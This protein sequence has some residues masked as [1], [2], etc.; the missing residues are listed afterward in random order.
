[1]YDVN[2]EQ[3]LNFAPRKGEADPDSNEDD[4][5]PGCLPSQVF[6][7][8]RSLAE[9][10]SVAVTEKQ[11]LIKQENSQNSDTSETLSTEGFESD[12]NK[13][14]SSDSNISFAI[15]SIHHF[16]QSV[17]V[18]STPT[19]I[20]QIEGINSTDPLTP[21]ANLKMLMSVVSPAIRDLE[22]KRKDLFY[23]DGESVAEEVVIEKPIVY[24][25]KDKS[26]GLLCQ[27]FL[28]KFPEN[29][30]NNPIEISL[31]EVSKDLKVERRR[32]Y[33]IVNVLESVEVLSRVAKNRYLW[34]GKTRIAQTLGRLKVLSK[35]QELTPPRRNGKENAN[36]TPNTS[37][38]KM[39]RHFSAGDL[40]KWKNCGT[41]MDNRGLKDRDLTKEE[42]RM[43]IKAA[44]DSTDHC[45]KDKSLGVLS[46]KFLIMFLLSKGGVV[47]L[48]DAA[49]VLLDEKD[50]GN[51]KYKT[52]VRR[53]YDIANIL[54]SLELIEKVHIRGPSGK[55]P[56]FKWIGVDIDSLPENAMPTGPVLTFKTKHSLLPDSNGFIQ[57]KRPAT[58]TRQSLLLPL[59]HIANGN[60]ADPNVRWSKSASCNASFV[61]RSSATKGEESNTNTASAPDGFLVHEFAASP[62]NVLGRDMPLYSPTDVTFRD[63]IQK[64]QERF[65][66]RMSQLLAVLPFNSPYPASGGKSSRRNLFCKSKSCSAPGKMDAPDPKRLRR[67]SFG[68]FKTTES[69]GPAS[70]NTETKV[71][72]QDINQANDENTDP[73]KVDS[74]AKFMHSTN[75]PFKVMTACQTNDCQFNMAAVNTSSQPNLS[76]NETQALEDRRKQAVLQEQRQIYQR[77]GAQWRHMVGQ[78]PRYE[79]GASPRMVEL[80]DQAVSPIPPGKLVP[81]ASIAVQASLIKD[82]SPLKPLVFLHHRIPSPWK[83]PGASPISVP[84]APPSTPELPNELAGVAFQSQVYLRSVSPYPISGSKSCSSSPVGPFS[85]AKLFF[86]P[87]PS[88][89]TSSINNLVLPQASLLYNVNQIMSSTSPANMTS[90]QTNHHS[91]SCPPSVNPSPIPVDCGLAFGA[92]IVIPGA[93][94]SNP[95][96]AQIAV[97]L[98]M[99][100]QNPGQ[101]FSRPATMTPSPQ[102]SNF[103]P[104]QYRQPLTACPGAKNP[105]MVGYTGG[106][107]ETPSYNMDETLKDTVSRKLCLTNE[108]S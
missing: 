7:R 56:G 66:N 30:G 60:S 79:R 74:Q 15:T 86:P 107:G 85:G 46:Q 3:S 51:V 80:V 83:Q 108:N 34:H 16:G 2:T 39:K 27:R 69:N 100:Q 26:L 47:T 98:S 53:L 104:C 12:E 32:V 49:N 75:S 78:M 67:N 6:Q 19:K 89:P 9:L 84:P 93:R 103:T 97:P 23:A 5:D 35:T 91:N 24:N 90:P 28:A 40:P 18:P 1:M 29:P 71:V 77:T 57:T 61:R 88:P 17:T 62:V 37:K 20:A 55:K 81:R 41:A 10:S 33:D 22:E 42:E 64:L 52:K 102:A 14:N 95:T 65:P 38:S 43:R 82:I 59:P 63:E 70:V 54:S 48:E 105:C 87:S 50:E 11:A 92:G 8:H 21:T 58:G 101:V 99:P 36:H 96:C 68:D 72:G 76:N 25:R 94:N 45:R 73:E 13:Y 106:L 44:I 4:N 31:D